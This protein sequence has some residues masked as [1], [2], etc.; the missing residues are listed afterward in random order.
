MRRSI[1]SWLAASSMAAAALLVSTPAPAQAEAAAAQGEPEVVER[2]PLDRSFIV[3]VVG[4]PSGPGLEGETLARR[5]HEVGL[6]LRCPVCQG[7]SVS[8]SPSPTAINMKNEVRDLLA[9]GFDQG[10]ILAWFEASYGQFVLMEPKT[11]GL[12]LVVWL[13]PVV[14]LVG[15]LVLVLLQLRKLRGRPDDEVEPAPPSWAGDG[16]AAEAR[17]IGGAAAQTSAAAAADTTTDDTTAR[18]GPRGPQGDPGLASYLNEV[19]KLAYGAADGG[20]P[21][22]KPTSTK[23]S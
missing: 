14:V 6:L 9:Q 3:G 1:L 8:D 21:A 16:I 15:G 5:T 11:E 19:Q 18:E 7:S 4:E 12:N 23:D 10:Q 17:T 22:S 13:G 2:A 20:A